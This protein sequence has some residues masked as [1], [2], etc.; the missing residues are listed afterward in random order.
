M[1]SQRR[2]CSRPARR[3][4]SSLAG[5]RISRNVDII[6]LINFT[7]FFLIVNRPW[8]YRAHYAFSSVCGTRSSERVMRYGV[9]TCIE[10]VKCAWVCCVFYRP[11]RCLFTHRRKIF[12]ILRASPTSSLRLGWYFWNIF[13]SGAVEEIS[14]HRSASGPYRSLLRELDLVDVKDSLRKFDDYV[15]SCLEA[16]LQGSDLRF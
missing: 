13:I 1:N 15:E 3:R 8:L 6:I 16:F 12:Y 11:H 10:C 14:S 2:T 7:L 4:T 9:C 5:R